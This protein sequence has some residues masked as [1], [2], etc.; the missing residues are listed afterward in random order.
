MTRP[1]VALVLLLALPA[2]AAAE[3]VRATGSFLFPPVMPEA[4][5]CQAAEERARAD[6]VR[7]VGGETL[8][9]EDILRCTEQG[10]EAD[11]ARNSTVWTAVGGDIRAVRGRTVET[12]AEVE[13][14]RKC[15]VALEA[16]VKVAEGR[17]DPG[18]DLGVALNNAVFR[19][20][21]ALVV[22]LKP[23]Q[24]MAV[25]IFQ[26]LPYEKGEAQIARIF[27]NAFD[28]AERID[29]P[30][31]VPTDTAARRYAMKVGFPVGM[32]AR[33]KMVDEYLMVV[34][35]RKPV[36]FRDAYSLDDFNRLLSELPRGDRRIVRRAYNIVRGGE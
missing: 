36:N 6:A 21:E 14:Y 23:S 29:R 16:D 10:D 1:L 9:A 18:F 19:D 32:P 5:A 12:A 27:P 15:T 26:W 31:T 35:T 11:C 4:E 34:A 13:G 28:T 30:V 24:P 25:Q 33:R 22:S 2:P 8:A 7:Q 20:G 3:W 17:A